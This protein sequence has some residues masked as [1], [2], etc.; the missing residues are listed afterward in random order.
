[1]F[2]FK[3]KF[4]LTL[5]LVSAAFCFFS[6]GNAQDSSDEAEET[7]PSFEDSAR[8]PPDDTEPV[9]AFNSLQDAVRAYDFESAWEM[10][11][12]N[13][14][15]VKFGGDVEIFKKHFENQEHY[16]AL[17]NFGIEKKDFLNNTTIEFLAADGS[18]YL[19]CKEGD[20]WKFNGRNREKD[21]QVKDD[22][23]KGNKKGQGKGGG[24]KKGGKHKGGGNKKE[25]KKNKA[26]T[27]E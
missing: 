13:L 17:V 3:K 20:T 19:M 26:L 14:R 16:H 7:D 9:N 1:M 4:F 2:L 23:S 10:L 21:L 12:Q 6:A 18:S 8:Q 5:L 24:G 27:S 25:G 22:K 15:Q 11:S